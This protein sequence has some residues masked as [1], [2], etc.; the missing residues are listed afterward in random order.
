[1]QSFEVV[2]QGHQENSGRPG[3]IMN[4]HPSYDQLHVKHDYLGQLVCLNKNFF[5]LLIENKS[6]LSTST[7]ITIQNNSYFTVINI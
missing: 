4:V 5:N 2:S 1:M 3:Q 6:D 7:C